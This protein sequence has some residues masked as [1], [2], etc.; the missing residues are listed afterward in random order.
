[1]TPDNQLSIDNLITSISLVLAD[2]QKE[3]ATLAEISE[4][5]ERIE[6]AHAVPL[7]YSL[8]EACSRLGFGT[9]WGNK[10]PEILPAPISNHPRRYRIEE[11]EALV[12]MGIPKGKRAP[13]RARTHR[14][15][16]LQEAV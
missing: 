2:R 6:R 3:K 12:R 13:R 16:R 7:C 11:V 14:T 8:R 10:H 1:M 5:L 4:R 15:D 9:G